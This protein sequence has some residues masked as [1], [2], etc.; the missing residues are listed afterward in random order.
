VCINGVQPE[1]GDSLVR[2]LISLIVIVSA[3]WSGYWFVGKTANERVIAAWLEDRRA[4][5]WTADYD[6]FA[7]V[8]FPNRFDTR[9]QGLRLASPYSGFGWT[10]PEFNILALSYKPNHIIAEF[11]RDQI[12]TTPIEE[13]RV[14]SDSMQASVVFEPDTELAVDRIA[15]TTANLSLQGGTGWRMA[16]EHLL[17]A[18]RQSDLSENAHDFVFEATRVTPTQ[19]FRMGLDPL[20]KLPAEISRANVDLT[21]GFTAPWDRIAIETGAPEVTVIVV[22][23]FSLTWGELELDASGTLDVA[24]NGQISGELR[25]KL[26]NWRDVLRLF[27]SG[28]VIGERLADTIES[29]LKLWNSGAGNPADIEVPLTLDGMLMS[30]GPVVIGPAPR[31]IRN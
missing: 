22:R 21:L 12:V 31:F 17:V 3:L 10:T 28:G 1:Q 18:T 13:I 6:E 15:L 8:G 2:F 16:A 23:T 5:G 9:F 11:A 4:A 20:G 19:A 25:L 26:R 30:I 14:L 7:V 29:G 24:R 27:V